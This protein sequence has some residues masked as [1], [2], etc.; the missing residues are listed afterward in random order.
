MRSMEAYPRAAMEPGDESTGRDVAD[1]EEDHLVAGGGDP[2]DQRPAHAAL[3]GTLRRRGLQRVVRPTAR[4][5]VE[6]AG[7][8]GDG[9]GSVL[10]VPGEKFPSQRAT[11]SPEIASPRPDP[12]ELHP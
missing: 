1:G 10:V 5:A 6:T 3:A 11:P 2:W 7:A 12:N 4:A 8:R 9:G